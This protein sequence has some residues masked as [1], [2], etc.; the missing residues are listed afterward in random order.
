[1]I[2]IYLFYLA[3]V[4]F[5]F[6]WFMPRHGVVD[7]IFKYGVPT[8]GLLLSIML[9][10]A[11]CTYGKSQWLLY[12]VAATLFFLSDLN[13]ILEGIVGFGKHDLLGLFIFTW[14]TYPIT[15]TLISLFGRKTLHFT[16][17]KTAI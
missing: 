13:V 6:L 15:I 8:Y 1:L 7:I 16:N 3:Y 2:P 9:W 5:C 11:I 12:S 10:R 14:A 4:L 17:L